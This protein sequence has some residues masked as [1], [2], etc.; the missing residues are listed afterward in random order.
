MAEEFRDL[1]PMTQIVSVI[2]ERVARLS[3]DLELGI[4]V[5]TPPFLRHPPG[6]GGFMS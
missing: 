1:P 2:G 6:W 5:D 4:D 3:R